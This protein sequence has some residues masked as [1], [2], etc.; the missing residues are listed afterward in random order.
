M[1]KGIT[2][3]DLVLLTKGRVAEFSATLFFDNEKK[4][5]F[6]RVVYGD[7]KYILITQRKSIRV[8]KTASSALVC[9]SRLNFNSVLVKDFNG[10][11]CIK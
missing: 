4:G 6:L 11:V 5:A 7:K 10:F 2:Y 9:L 3:K 8:F 1:E